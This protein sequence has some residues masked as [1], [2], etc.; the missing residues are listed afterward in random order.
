MPMLTIMPAGQ[1]IEA[2]EGAS[3]LAALLAA[4]EKIIPTV[5]DVANFVYRVG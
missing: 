1:T 2:A 4:D 5:P 3:I